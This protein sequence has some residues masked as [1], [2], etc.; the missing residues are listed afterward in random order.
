MGRAFFDLRGLD[1]VLLAANRAALA[2]TVVGLV[3]AA[4]SLVGRFRHARGVERLPLALG[5]AGRGAGGVGGAAGVLFTPG[6][7]GCRPPGPC[8]TSGRQL[9]P[10]GPTRW[11]PGRRCCATALMTWTTSSAAPWPTGCSPWS[12]AAAT[13]WSYSG[14]ASSWAATAAWW[15]RPPPWP[16][17]RCL[18]RASRRLQSRAVDR[19]FNRRRHDATRIIEGFG[20]R[21]RDQVDLDTLTTD[22]LAVVDQ[23]IQPTRASLWLRT[24]PEPSRTRP[25]ARPRDDTDGTG[26]H[27]ARDSNPQ[28]PDP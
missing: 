13:P 20:A 16:W 19:R 21:L 22:L 15:S 26:W 7:R 6:G 3:A 10:G 24:P 28:P 2:V 11:P 5:G 23:A 8:S 4:A 14:S 25:G 27:A 17:R 12:W 9:L 1:G 18:S